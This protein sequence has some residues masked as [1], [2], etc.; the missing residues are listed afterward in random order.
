MEW[1]EQTLEAINARRGWLKPLSLDSVVSEACRKHANY[2]IRLG[3][4]EH[5]KE[6]L[7]KEWT[8]NL[9]QVKYSA[10][11]QSASPQEISK[12]I[13]SLVEEM[14]SSKKSFENLKKARERVAIGFSALGNR[15]VM[16]V[17]LK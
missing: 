16:V 3:K 7:L 11:V 2:L 4:L 9:A 10:D 12:V 5:A 6:S 17:R 14:F 13:H 8:E 1:E 15:L